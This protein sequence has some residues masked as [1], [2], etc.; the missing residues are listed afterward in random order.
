[1]LPLANCEGR[2]EILNWWQETFERN[3][4]LTFWRHFDAYSN[5]AN[6]KKDNDLDVS[7]YEP[8]WMF[9]TLMLCLVI[10]QVKELML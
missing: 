6:L 1:M 8:Y 5:F 10:N 7:I 9:Q 4:A 3:G 2:F